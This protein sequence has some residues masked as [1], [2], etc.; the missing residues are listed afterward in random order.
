MISSCVAS[1]LALFPYRAI[2]EAFAAKLGT[3]ARARLFVDA[4]FAEL[5][6]RWARAHGALLAQLV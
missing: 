3:D 2:A 5:R 4:G 1:Q 6:E